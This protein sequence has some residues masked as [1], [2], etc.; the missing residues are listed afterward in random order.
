[1]AK[2]LDDSQL[3]RLAS[4]PR[5]RLFPS[6]GRAAVFGPLVILT[7]MI[8]CLAAVFGAELGDMSAGWGLRA[9]DVAS[10]DD[11]QEWLEP[12]LNGLGNGYVYQPPLSSWL[13]ALTAPR[14]GSGGVLGWRALSLAFGICAVWSVYLLGRRLDGASF[15][16]AA[17]AVLSGHPVILRLATETSPASLGILMIVIAVWG[18]L[19]H[20]EGPPQLV[21]M[22]MLAGSVAWGLALLA[23]GPVAAVLII[24]MLV[25]SW[26]LHGGRHDG[27]GRSLAARLWQLWLGTRAL[28]LFVFTALSFS[29]WWQIMMLTNHGGEFWGAWWTG[30]VGMNLPSNN[31]GSFWP[32][33]LAQNSLLVGWLLLGLTSAVREL[34]N[35]ASEATR[36]RSQFVLVWWLAALLA[37]ILFDSPGLRRS[38]QIDAWDALLLVPSALLAARGIKSFVLRQTRLAGETA[39][40]AVPVGL[41]AWRIFRHP[42][43]GLAAFVLCLTAIVLLPV[44]IPQVRAGARRF[45]ERDW[46]QLLRIAFVFLIAGHAVAGL[47]EFPRPS[48]ESRTLTE[49]RKQI[50]PVASVARVTLNGAVPESLLFVLRSRWPTAQFVTAGSHE[51]KSDGEFAGAAARHEVVIE[52][53]Q[54]EIR[55]TNEF[56]ADRQAVNIVEPIRFRERRLMIYRKA[57]RRHPETAGNVGSATRDPPVPIRPAALSRRDS[58]SSSGTRSGRSFVRP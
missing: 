26:L 53:T 56:P 12:G 4:D 22:R 58:A 43:P 17:A 30:R 54:R 55:V 50:A 48:Q 51:G 32:E 49:L 7:A 39:M 47:V 15:G 35:P 29:C 24:P 3:L 42:W 45:T 2:P 46:R 1:M 11:I 6:F 38:A 16:F 34:G 14:L 13:L 10:A 33:W 5:T 20:L 23:V 36:R 52:W 18:F 9:L 44:V 8:P 31:P 21:S 27:P 28:A 57:P 40:I 19:G 37:R 41:T 25:H